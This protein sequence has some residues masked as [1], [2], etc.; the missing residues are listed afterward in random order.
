MTSVHDL[1]NSIN[2]LAYQLQKHADDIEFEDYDRGDISDLKDIDATL[3]DMLD[4]FE[5]QL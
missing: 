3:A 1:L 2:Y 5:D 4:Y